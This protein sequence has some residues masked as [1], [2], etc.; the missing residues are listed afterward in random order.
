M[1]KGDCRRKAKRSSGDQWGCYWL[2][3]GR[4]EGGRVNKFAMAFD[5]SIVNTFFEKRPHHLVT[6]KSGGRKSQ[7]DF[8]MCKRQQLNE[9]QKCMVIKSTGKLWRRRTECYC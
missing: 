7:I 1:R 3:S 9:V 6:Y 8:L 4:E 5:L 2:G